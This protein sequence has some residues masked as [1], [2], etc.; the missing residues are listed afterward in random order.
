VYRSS[1][2]LLA[3]LYATLAVLVAHGTFAGLDQWA[4]DHTMPGARFGTHGPSTLQA[5]VPL[6]YAHWQ[7]AYSVA[8]NIVTLPASGLFSAFVVAFCCVRLLRRGDRTGAGVWAAALVLGDCVELLCKGV[9]ER[10]RLHAGTVQLKPFDSSFP[11]G[12]V[13]RALL[14]AAVVA[15]VWRRARLAAA[16]W[17]LVSVALVE[18][19]GW[20]TP[21]DMAGAVVLAAVLATAATATASRPSSWSTARGAAAPTTPARPWR[22]GRPSARE[23]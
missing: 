7:S 21:S 16:A 2:A 11:S 20:H 10:P 19:V 12:H 4:V 17:A 6:A 3:G 23:R 18:L 5:I 15:Y 8:A 14:V 1:L 13:L 22:G 9:L